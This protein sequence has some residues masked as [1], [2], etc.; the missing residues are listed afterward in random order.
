MSPLVLLFDID[1]TLVDT[2]GAGRRA[3]LRAFD[4]HAKGRDEAWKRLERIAFAGMT[5]RAIARAGLAAVDQEASDAALDA[6]LR[7]Y[8]EHLV[9]EI[10]QTPSYI[11]HP[12]VQEALARAKARPACGLGLGTGN[13]REGARLKLGKG[14]IYDAF[15]FGGFGCDHE[16]RAEILRVGAQRGAAH[17]GVALQSCRV[18]VIGDTP[19]D[20]AAAQAIGAECVAVATGRFTVEQLA[21]HEPTNVFADLTAEG[22]LAA[23][24]GH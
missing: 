5:D 16:D 12:G 7:T 22:A 2:G 4:A 3:M 20:I 17:L 10:S 23:V 6:V 21:R 18:V 15:A 1:G 8:L 13:L 9:T 11:I 19:R 14:G 24:F